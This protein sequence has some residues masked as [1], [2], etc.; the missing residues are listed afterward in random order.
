MSYAAVLWPGTYNTLH[1]GG[2]S[3]RINVSLIVTWSDKEELIAFLNVR[4]C[5]FISN[6]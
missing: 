4:L 3:I 2:L 6:S 5:V 1:A